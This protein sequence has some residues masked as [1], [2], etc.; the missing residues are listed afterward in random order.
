MKKMRLFVSIII[1]SL[2]F[3][4]M[5]M[6]RANC[7]DFDIIEVFK[8]IPDSLFGFEA[9]FT[10][11]QFSQDA[12]NRLFQDSFYNDSITS[13]SVESDALF[14]IVD[15]ENLDYMETSSYSVNIYKDL[16]WLNL[17]YYGEYYWTGFDFFLLPEGDSYSFILLKQYTEQFG[18]AGVKEISSYYFDRKANKYVKKEISLP[19]LDWADFYTAED[20]SKLNMYYLEGLSPSYTITLLDFDNEI[21]LSIEADLDDVTMRFYGTMD[22]VFT[23][24]RNQY[25]DHYMCYDSLGFRDL[26]EARPFYYSFPDFAL[27][28]EQEFELM[29]LFNSFCEKYAHDWDMDFFFQPNRAGIAVNSQDV[30]YEVKFSDSVMNISSEMMNDLD[31][32]VILL[33]VDNRDYFILCYNSKGFVSES[34]IRIF[35]CDKFILYEELTDKFIKKFGNNDFRIDYPENV[36]EKYSEVFS[37]QYD[38]ENDT[39]FISFL[40]NPPIGNKEAESII[41]NMDT[42]DATF[43]YNLRDLLKRK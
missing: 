40:I 21:V 17:N 15:V 11:L 37:L 9:D 42:W 25:E 13:Y 8:E 26:S 27:L 43:E 12:R 38:I 28:D 23:E 3:P 24:F 5:L 36:F 35:N 6:Q 18:M 31:I 4:F 34:Q 7:Q 10:E 39:L 20:V 33:N 41:N 1:T 22:H 29:Y 2:L 30:E 14:G 16:N 32:K 19:E